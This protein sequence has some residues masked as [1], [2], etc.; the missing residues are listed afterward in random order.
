MA[1]GVLPKTNKKLID[2]LQNLNH[3]KKTKILHLKKKHHKSDF[4]QPSQ[5]QSTS[6]FNN[7]VSFN[8]LTGAPIPSHPQSA[9]KFR[10]YQSS[11]ISSSSSNNLLKI[12]MKSSHVKNSFKKNQNL[13]IPRSSKHI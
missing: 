9:T 10:K 5:L 8:F 1:P 2:V 11:H 7:P 6:I 12:A 3:S 13:L 4:F